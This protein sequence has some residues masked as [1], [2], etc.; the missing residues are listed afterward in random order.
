MSLHESYLQRLC[1]V[2]AQI[3]TKFFTLVTIWWCSS[4]VR[5]YLLGLGQ[6]SLK[7]DLC[8]TLE[9]ARAYYKL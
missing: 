2:N 5:N 3:R 9:N 1:Q 7:T 4:R 8:S 6:D